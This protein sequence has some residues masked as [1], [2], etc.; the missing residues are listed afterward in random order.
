MNKQ[1]VEKIADQALE[2]IALA[3]VPKQGKINNWHLNEE[4]YYAKKRKL[5]ESRANVSL[6]RT[7]E[8]V[9]TLL[10]KIDNP[11]VFEFTKRKNSQLKRVQN[12]NSLRQSDQDSGFWDLKDIVGKK[13][14]I[15]YGR[16]I[17]WYYADSINREYRSHY[18]P[19]DVYDFLIDPTCGGLDIEEARH[20]GCYSVS[21]DKR[22][23]KEGAKNKQFYKW[24]VDELLNGSGN[25]SEQSQEETN[26]QARVYDTNLTQNKQ[27]TDPTRYKFWRWL[28]TWQEDGD[29]Y[30]LVLDNSG[31]CIR[32]QPLKELFSTPRGMDYPMWP[33]WTWAA[34]PDMTEFWTPSYV[35]YVRDIFMAQDVSINQML[36]NAEAINKPMRVVNIT[37]IENLAELKYRRDGIIKTKGDYDIN[38]VYQTIQIPSIN[39]PIQVYNLLEQIQAKASG[40]TDGTAGVADESGKVGI[41]EGNQTAAADRFGLLSKSYSFGYKRFAKLYEIG[42]R[43]HLTKKV[44]VDI[45][46]PD[47][48]EV[49]DIKRTDIFKKDDDFGVM[50]TAS[51]AQ[52]LASEQDKK[53]KLNFL[54]SQAQNQKINQ[55]KSFE[56][57]ANI[58]GFTED[59]IEQLLDTAT[60]GNSELMSECDRDLESLLEDE[61][62]QPNELANNAYK[63]RMVD[64]LRDHKE[65]INMQQFERI[66]A[67]I[68]TL[69]P[70]IMRNEARQFQNEQIDQ[71]RQMRAMPPD[72]ATTEQLPDQIQLLN[73][74]QPYGDIQS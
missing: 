5:E 23:L 22:K 24:A 17:N 18:E 70:I 20:L 68:D 55:Q 3:R 6:G 16:S 29:R 60:Y 54:A 27:T 34:F 72:G 47:G 14:A 4:L 25:Y 71:M 61:E 62:I 12:L 33:V 41:Y 65:D 1:T 10:S 36:D 21:L 40:V 48:V 42:V 2:E 7:Q 44:A 50:V 63:Q 8:F 59:E 74:E 66:A 53:L 69:D 31:R 56:M 52:T 73:Q 64:Y 15:I 13:Q 51:N 49:R 30:Y 35:D 37:A 38:R 39:T 67:Y 26:K 11:I 9:H 46:G 43:D 45:I 19:I 32:C 28:T 57:Q 58:S